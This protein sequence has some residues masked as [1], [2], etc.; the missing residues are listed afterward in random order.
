MQLMFF[1]YLQCCIFSWIVF[2]VVYFLGLCSLSYIFLDCLL[3]SIFSWIVF[4]VYIFFDFLLSSILSW[5]VF[6]VLCF[7]WIV[8]YA[9]YFLWLSPMLYNFLGCLLGYNF[10]FQMPRFLDFLLHALYIFLERILF[11]IFPG[12]SSMQ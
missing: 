3:C 6:Y 2:Y 8:F 9:I 11:Y 7:G 12:L 1:D 5:T 10:F 4:Y